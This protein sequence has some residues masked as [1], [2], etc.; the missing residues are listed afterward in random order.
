MNWSSGE[1]TEAGRKSSQRLLETLA[2]AGRIMIQRPT[3]HRAVCVKLSDET[4]AATRS[5][6]GLPGMR[7]AYLAMKELSRLGGHVSE[8]QMTD[9]SLWPDDQQALENMF[10]PH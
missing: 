5:L 6:C 7:G 8:F 10:S 2:D 3:S 9:R 1:T 4:E